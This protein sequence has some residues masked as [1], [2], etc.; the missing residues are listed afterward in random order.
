MFYKKQGIELVAEQLLVSQEGLLSLTL[1]F[2]IYND[3]DNNN[4]GNL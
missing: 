2:I 1:I 4:G 3:L